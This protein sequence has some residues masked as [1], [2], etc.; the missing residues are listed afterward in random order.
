M[1]VFLGGRQEEKEGMTPPVGVRKDQKWVEDMARSCKHRV[2]QEKNKGSADQQGCM[3]LNRNHSRLMPGMAEC[4][5]AMQHPK[6]QLL[7]MLPI[8]DERDRIQQSDQ[9]FQNRE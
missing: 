6:D 4:S 2:N 3:E 8:E 7:V 1:V 9:L 5:R